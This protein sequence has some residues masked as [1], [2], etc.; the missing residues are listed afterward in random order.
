MKLTLGKIADWIHAEGEF[1]TGAE[2]LGYS[3]DSRTIGAGDLFF[4]VRGERVDGHEYVETAL[5]NGAVAAVV[6]MRW[7]A[8]VGVDE[9]RLLRVPDS[10]ADCVL[11]SMQTLAHAV[12]RAWGKKVIGVTG[13][14]GKTTTKE[15]IAAVLSAKFRVLKTEGNLNNHFGVPL[16]LL[17]LER[18]HEVAVLE[19]GMNHAGEIR[20]LAKIAEPD[21]AVVSNVA[22][23]HLE[24]FADGIEGIARAKYELVDSLPRDGVAVLNGDDER[25][26]EFGRGMGE[27]AVLYGTRDGCTVRAAAIEDHGLRGTDF[28]VEV[29]SRKLR[30]RV[31]S[32]PMTLHLTGRHN[33]MNALAAVAVGCMNEVELGDAC[34]ILERM[35]PTEKRGNV[36]AWQ[37]AEI[38]NDTYNSNPHALGA[39]VEALR[40]TP[41]KRR[42]VV[43]GE[44]LELGPVGASLHGS[45]GASMSGLDF[46]LGVRG[47]AKSLVDGATAAGIAAEFMETPEQAGEWLRANLREGDVVLLKASRGVRLEG[48]LEALGG[49]ELRPC[50]EGDSSIEVPKGNDRMNIDDAG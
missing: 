1:N 29:E 11:Q 17:R 44:M 9:A 13:S 33:V 47:L 3:I 48:A 12:R 27:R 39:M 37:G 19:M 42:I 49:R 23:V 18:E 43:A 20:A 26:R 31:L 35:R 6:S 16:T 10:H 14:A 50:T 36:L 32:W 22:G 25:V 2:A 15:C 34:S 41:A 4:A 30:G 21:C 45:C 38:V 28:V 40:A 46:V 7:L 24:F 5:L 8:P